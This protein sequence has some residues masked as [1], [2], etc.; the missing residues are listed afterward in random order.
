[1]ISFEKSY[2]SRKY[3]KP[4]GALGRS[5]GSL[6]KAPDKLSKRKEPGQHTAD[7]HAQIPMPRGYCCS[8]SHS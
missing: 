5:N 4:S 8:G 7:P 1:M 2:E 3:G 6:T